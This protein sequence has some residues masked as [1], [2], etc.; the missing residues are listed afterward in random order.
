MS[1]S[2]KGFNEVI[3]KS[4]GSSTIGTRNKRPGMALLSAERKTSQI[5]KITGRVLE[6]KVYW[7]SD[8]RER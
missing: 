6:R 4:S 8:S 2:L 7:K 5:F 1:A 3:M